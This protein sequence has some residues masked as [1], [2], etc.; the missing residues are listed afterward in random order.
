MPQARRNGL[1][2]YM[3]GLFSRTIPRHLFAKRKI[4]VEL[5]NSGEDAITV[6]DAG[7]AQALPGATVTAQGFIADR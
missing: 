3:N 5:I 7:R 4:E 2:G 6:D 1:V